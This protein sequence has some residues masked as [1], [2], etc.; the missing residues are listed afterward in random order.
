[1]QNWLS[2]NAAWVV[3]FLAAVFRNEW[4]TNK[5]NKA[6][7]DNKTGFL[8]LKTNK[9]CEKCMVRCQEATNATLRRVEENNIA[10][11]KA[12]ADATHELSVKL[13]KI[14]DHLLEGKK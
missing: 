11:V 7:F 14:I 3:A 4:T 1:M 10:A 2:D 6:V 12:Q 9:D 5:L 13:D 8:Q